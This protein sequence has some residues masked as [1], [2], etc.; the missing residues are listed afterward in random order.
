[1]CQIGH[2]SLAIIQ[3]IYLLTPTPRPSIKDRARS[4]QQLE[5]EK[6]PNV[7]GDPLESEAALALLSEE[8]VGA[9]L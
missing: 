8:E 5:P 7:L 9:G 6:H 2:P 1:M 3:L 4:S